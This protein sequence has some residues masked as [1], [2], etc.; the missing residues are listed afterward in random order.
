M[1]MCI[2]IFLSR[3]LDPVFISADFPVKYLFDRFNITTTTTTIVS[4][5]VLALSTICLLP[6]LRGIKLSFM[7]KINLQI[8]GSIG[9]F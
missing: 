4:A 3:S 2:D 8:C 6:F 1:L 7:F 9:V 5:K